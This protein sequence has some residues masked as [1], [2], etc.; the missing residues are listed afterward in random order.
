MSTEEAIRILTEA[1]H[2]AVMAVIM[3]GAEQAELAADIVEAL[4][5]A[6]DALTDS[7]D[8]DALLYDVYDEEDSEDDR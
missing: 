8:D 5:M 3:L 1:Q 6:I 7:G 2:N 4:G